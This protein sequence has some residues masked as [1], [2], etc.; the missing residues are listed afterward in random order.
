MI[1]KRN[2]KEGEEITCAYGPAYAKLLRQKIK[3]HQEHCMKL[4]REHE[5]L[6]ASSVRVVN[7]KYSW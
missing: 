5:A 7:H 1:A 3:L 2:I 6:I 4:E